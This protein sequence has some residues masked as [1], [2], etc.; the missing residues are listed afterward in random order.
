MVTP[1]LLSILNFCLGAFLLLN[2]MVSLIASNKGKMDAI[3]ATIK[4][5]VL[6]IAGNIVVNCIPAI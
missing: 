6:I 3:T 5:I 1:D 2:D 4:M